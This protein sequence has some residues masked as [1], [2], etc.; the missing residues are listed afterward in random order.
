MEVARQNQPDA[1]VGEPLERLRRPAD[2]P[3]ARL[4]LR[5]Q[6]WMVR[7]HDAHPVAGRAIEL[8][9]R[10]LDLAPADAPVRPVQLQRHAPRGVDA[11]N[12][13]V[14]ADMHRLGRF[15]DEGAIGA[16]RV[17][18]AFEQPVRR[19]VVIARNRQPRHVEA[20]QILPRRQKLRIVRAL[21]QVAG[22]QDQVGGMVEEIGDQRLRRLVVDA[23]E[24]QIGNMSQNRHL[25]AAASKVGSSGS[26][27]TSVSTDLLGPSTRSAF[28]RIR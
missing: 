15:V 17:G 22:D 6:E 1:G 28:G 24:V 16:K 10:P 9:N 11:D 20:V 18:E 12:H 3:R 14:V 19:D 27:G 23:A 2:E 4:V 8:L 5:R 21:R 13:H 7:H 25:E 26:V